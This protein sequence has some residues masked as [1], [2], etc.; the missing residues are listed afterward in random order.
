MPVKNVCMYV[1]IGIGAVLISKLVVHFLDFAVAGV[2]KRTR[3]F[4]PMCTHAYIVPL[5]KKDSGSYGDLVMAYPKPHSIYLRGAMYIYIY[6]Y[7][8]AYRCAYMFICI[9]ILSIVEAL[10]LSPSERTRSSGP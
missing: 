4:G 10:V 5:K 7:V 8:Y 3:M 2:C 6:T 1:C 9:Y